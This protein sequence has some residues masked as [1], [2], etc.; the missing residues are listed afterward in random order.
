MPTVKIKD[1]VRKIKVSYFKPRGLYRK[2]M[3]GRMFYLGPDKQTAKKLV[4]VIGTL[5]V[6][7]KEEGK[8]WQEEDLEFIRMAREQLYQGRGRVVLKWGD[9]HFEL[10]HGK[11]SDLEPATKRS[12]GRS[13][14]EGH[15][16][17][18]VGEA[19]KAFKKQLSY[20]PLIAD[21]HR[22]TM[23][24]KIDSLQSVLSPDRALAS[25]GHDQLTRL[26]SKL[27]GRPKSTTTGKKIAAQTAI[28]LIAAA[29]QFF[30]WLRDSGR[31]GEPRG[32]ERIFRVNRRALLTNRERKQA[33]Q[34]VDVFTV[35]ELKKLWK[36]A[37][38]QNRLFICLGTNCGF[39]QMEIATLRTW[40]I[41]LEADP[42]RIAR[43]RRK[44]E[45]YG[46]WV[47]WDVT[48][49]LLAR[50]LERTPRNAEEYALLTRNGK[51]YVRYTNGNRTDAIGQAWQKLV[52]K[53]GV[54]RLGFK[55]LRKTG[56]DMIRRIGG[57]EVSEAYLAHSEK[58]L[59]RVY[60]NRDFDKLAEALE[61]M[62]A[63]LAPVFA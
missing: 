41:D 11:R 22:S 20:D 36:A 29:R 61:K 53:A 43:H 54:T 42:K 8:E 12:R 3:G 38:E 24:S 5:H 9:T 21:S 46:S 1:Y 15:G 56:A 51:P 27:A 57:L 31:W 32:F 30:Y 19:M 7:R 50:R 60:S 6:V 39:A 23:T 13:K 26:V 35:D 37:N 52:K 2:Y 10:V 25:I 40:E 49:D 45:V 62:E 17:G 59:A 47:L 55:H 18:T 48:A 63:E 34:G 58:T 16:E 44:T 4:V 33:A 28:N 14:D